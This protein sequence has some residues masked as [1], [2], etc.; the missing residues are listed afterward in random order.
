MEGGSYSSSVMCLRFIKVCWTCD[1]FYSFSF[2]LRADRPS[3]LR[4]SSVLVW[5]NN[6]AWNLCSFSL[7][8][9]FSTCLRSEATYL[10]SLYIILPTASALLS[11][12][13]IFCTFWEMVSCLFPSS[14]ISGCAF[15]NCTL[16]LVSLIG[17]RGL[18][19]RLI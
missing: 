3:C 12:L 6:S 16:P 9:C 18:T 17:A 19:S 5:L 10:Y 2:K 7:V 4:A 11:V 8:K 14:M 1:G 15:S 13:C